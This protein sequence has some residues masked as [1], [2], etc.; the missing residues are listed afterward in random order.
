MTSPPI[1]GRNFGMLIMKS[2]ISSIVRSYKLKAEDVGPLKIEMLL[3]PIKGHQLKISRRWIQFRCNALNLSD[4]ANSCS[5][6]KTYVTLLNV[7]PL[8]QCFGSI[9]TKLL[10]HI[11]GGGAKSHLILLLCWCSVYIPFFRFVVNL[12]NTWDLLSVRQLFIVDMLKNRI[13][14]K[15]FWT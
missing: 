8:N 14:L 1:P 6:L 10:H 3:F 4:Y 9:I 7:K 12:Y 11:M 15:I 5:F 2:V 13:C